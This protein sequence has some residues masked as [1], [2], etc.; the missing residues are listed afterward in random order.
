MK[1]HSVGEDQAAYAQGFAARFDLLVRVRY[2]S[3]RTLAIDVKIRE[4]DVTD[5]KR[6]LVLPTLPMAIRLAEALRVP[7]PLLVE[8]ATVGELLGYLQ[9]EHGAS[10]TQGE[11]PGS[12]PA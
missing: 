7:L 5:L 3:Q 9:R 8:D 12:R 2:P 6:G 1:F 4:A 10:A 11:G